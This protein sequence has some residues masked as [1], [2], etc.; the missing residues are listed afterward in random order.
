MMD[1]EQNINDA[2][3]KAM[4]SKND[5]EL[6]A[7]RAIKSAII[8]FKTA[9]EFT[10]KMEE[11]AKIKILQKLIKQRNDSI[12]IYETQNRQELSKKEKEE[13][14]IIEQFLPKQ[15]SQEDLTKIILEIKQES[16]I[17]SISEMGKLIG[18]VNKKVAGQADGKTISNLV[19][20]L[21]K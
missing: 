4:L 13:I 3:K 5:I 20:E 17:S 15:L 14:E 9:P 16:N 18:L 11:D 6:R 19:K 21:L 2:I 10:G 7:L 1:F 12:A 8:I